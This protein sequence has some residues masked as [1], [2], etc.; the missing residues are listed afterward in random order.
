MANL[1]EMVAV[2]LLKQE[3]ASDR[4]QGVIWGAKVAD[5]HSNILTEL[6]T[7]LNNDPN[8]NVR[9]A[10]ANALYLYRNNPH[11][12]EGLINSLTLQD[13]PLVQIALVD[14]LV[15]IKEEKALSALKELIKANHLNPEVKKRA[16]LGI[17]QLM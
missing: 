12:K 17:N 4:L 2:N 16:E 11:I 1:Q 3:S 15:E 7:T 13:S 5:Q 8:V 6:M 14:L 9:L 10:A